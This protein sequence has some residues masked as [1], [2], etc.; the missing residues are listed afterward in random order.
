MCLWWRPA[1]NLIRRKTVTVI[2]AGYTQNLYPHTIH[3]GNSVFFFSKTPQFPKFHH[4]PLPPTSLSSSHSPSAYLEAIVCL[5]SP[6]LYPIYLPARCLLWSPQPYR[7]CDQTCLHPLWTRRRQKKK[8][9]VTLFFRAFP[10]YFCFTI[11]WYPIL[12][13]F[14]S[15]FML[16]C[17]KLP[18]RKVPFLVW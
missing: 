8:V 13:A 11:L 5:A 10:S 12:W 6:I 14:C 16:F 4:I 9:R 1:A 7:L 17:I 15:R 3:D 2:Y 18:K